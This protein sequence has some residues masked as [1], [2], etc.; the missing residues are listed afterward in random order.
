[1]TYA[2]DF[3]LGI[4]KSLSDDEFSDEPVLF[5]RDG[6]L[7][8]ASEQGFGQVNYGLRTAPQEGNGEQPPEITESTDAILG[9]EG[10]GRGTKPIVNQPERA[11]L[12]AIAYGPDRRSFTLDEMAKTA[13]E[14]RKLSDDG[15]IRMISHGSS[16][17]SHKGGYGM[18]GTDVWVREARVMDR[19]RYLGLLREREDALLKEMEFQLRSGRGNLSHRYT[20]V[21]FPDCVIL[22][23][24]MMVTL[25]RRGMLDSFGP[26]HWTTRT[27]L[28][29]I[30]PLSADILHHGEVNSFS[31][32]PFAVEVKLNAQNVGPISSDGKELVGIPE[33]LAHELRAVTNN[34]DL[35]NQFIA[36]M[37]ALHDRLCAE[38]IEWSKEMRS[39]SE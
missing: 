35:A 32:S 6:S 7:H 34:L 2:V 29:A 23:P 20:Q 3:V 4:M 16:Y 14:L 22:T 26:E 21:K 28:G 38:D 18:D 8:I 27:Q 19:E 1:M 39:R 36:K 30:Y 13:R 24:Y 11:Y 25:P 12:T 5:Q 31:E 9:W 33:T 37:N 10:E 17:H 15:K